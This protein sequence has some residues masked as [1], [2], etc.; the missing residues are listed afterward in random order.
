MS[1]AVAPVADP[2]FT[3]PAGVRCAAS[4]TFDDGRRSQVEEGVPLFDRYGVRATFY[5]SMG[6]VRPVLAEWQRAADGGH[7]LG[8][9]TL[10]HPCSANFGFSSCPSTTLEGMTLADME[11]QLIES[12][13]QIEELFGVRPV[14]F[15][16]PCGQK[17]VGRGEGLHSYVPLVA[18]HYLTGRGWRD[19]YFNAPDR[20]DLA[21]LSG[22]EFDGSDFEQVRAQ[23]E[24]AARTGNWLVLAGHDIS[25]DVRR[26]VTMTATLEALCRYCQDPANG[27]WID[28]VGAIGTYIRKTRGF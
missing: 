16:Y 21:Q 13:R 26:Q 11:A 6:N 2:D 22:V 7:E 14:S 10:T 8:G 18:R 28:T 20:C 3:W 9:H 12:N 19:E 5:V 15:A 4:L 17:F 23:I 25:S 24:D 1:P 27:I